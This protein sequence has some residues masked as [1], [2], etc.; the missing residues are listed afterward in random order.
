VSYISEKIISEVYG[1][2]HEIKTLKS[3]LGMMASDLHLQI[4]S[5]CYMR[6]NKVDEQT[7]DQVTELKNKPYLTPEAL[8]KIYGKKF[9]QESSLQE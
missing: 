4:R 1:L 2:E 7:K 8:R 9:Q 5:P 3:L 6:N